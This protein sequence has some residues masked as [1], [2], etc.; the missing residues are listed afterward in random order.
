[1]MLRML[2]VGAFAAIGTMAGAACDTPEVQPSAT[3]WEISMPDD[4]WIAQSATYPGLQVPLFMASPSTPKIYEFVTLARY[5]NRIGL[6]QYYA[7]E[8][9]TSYLVTLVHNVVL[10]LEVN[11]VIGDAP[12]SED[13]VLAKWT[14]SDDEVEIQ[15]DYETTVFDLR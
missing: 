10:D 8:P 13:C 2:L 9:G 15:S 3:G 5:Q 4:E 12:F 1:M 6:L 11:R 14:W 7:G